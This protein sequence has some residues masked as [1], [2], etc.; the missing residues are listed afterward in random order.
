MKG[1]GCA[2]LFITYLFS[3]SRRLGWHD[4]FG[5][6]E[7]LL[8]RNKERNFEVGSKTCP[9]LFTAPHFYLVLTVVC[10]RAFV[11]SFCLKISREQLF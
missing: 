11:S 8:Y 4:F 5:H 3:F 2:L 10:W 6:E 7:Y 1:F 9:D